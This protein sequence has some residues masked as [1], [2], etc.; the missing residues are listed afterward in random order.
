MACK[1]KIDDDKTSLKA[2][3]VL[4]QQVAGRAA[5]SLRCTMFR[6][7]LFEKRDSKHKQI[8]LL[9]RSKLK[10]REARRYLINSLPAKV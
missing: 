9:M 3:E 2:S 8:L 6:S 1:I 10:R 5:N 4:Q 7:S